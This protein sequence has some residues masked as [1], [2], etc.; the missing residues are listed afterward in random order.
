MDES[1]TG[2]ER[3]AV[4]AGACGPN[5][6]FFGSYGALE[7]PAHIVRFTIFANANTELDQYP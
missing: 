1:I 5:A 6:T 2:P 3:L 4:M 7:A